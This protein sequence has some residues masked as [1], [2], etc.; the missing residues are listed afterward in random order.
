MLRARPHRRGRT[1]PRQGKEGGFARV[2]GD[3]LGW[4]KGES[5]AERQG[6]RD[7][8][9]ALGA[10]AGSARALRRRRSAAADIGPY[11]VVVGEIKKI[12]RVRLGG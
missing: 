1:F 10:L 7:S 8:N 11:P 2:G 3:A 4:R 9:L 6:G 5:A 12:H